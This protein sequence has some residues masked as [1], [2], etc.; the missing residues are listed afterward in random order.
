VNFRVVLAFVVLV[1]LVVV[2]GIAWKGWSALSGFAAEAQG[3]M[4]LCSSLTDTE[5]MD[6]VGLPTPTRLAGVEGDLDRYSCRWATKDYKS[7]V[8]YVEV[9]SAPAD[10]WAAQSKNAV[11]AQAGTVHNPARD[12]LIRKATR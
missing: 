11:L 9:L 7:V 10:E 4:R 6:L 2:G 1:G 8:A 5:R 3:K 12:A